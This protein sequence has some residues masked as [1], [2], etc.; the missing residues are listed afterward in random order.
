MV[1]AGAG[2]GHS[3]PVARD[4]EGNP[5][6]KSCHLGLGCPR[7]SKTWTEGASGKTSGKGAESPGAL[8]Q[9]G[10]KLQVNGRGL[11]MANGFLVQI[12]V[13]SHKHSPMEHFWEL[14]S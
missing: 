1:G 6:W 4:A 13:S 3:A 7:V 5:N 14:A 8:W 11:G 10:V 2:K 12:R 9:V